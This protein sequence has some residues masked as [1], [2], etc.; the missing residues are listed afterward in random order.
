MINCDICGFDFTDS[1]KIGGLKFGEKFVCPTCAPE[2]EDGLKRNKAEKHIKAR[3]PED[4]RFC[5]W[6]LSLRGGTIEEA[7]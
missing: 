1:Q 5:D 4:T 6:V 3:C 2:I 7:K